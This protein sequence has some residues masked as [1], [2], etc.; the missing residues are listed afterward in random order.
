V[1]KT[2]TYNGPLTSV[3]L[4]SGA[5]GEETAVILT[6]GITVPLPEENTYV[7][8]LVAL[9]RLTEVTTATTVGATGRAPLQKSKEEPPNAG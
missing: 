9:K 7:Q 5:D 4:T 1:K 6:D 2:Y 3:T 8:R